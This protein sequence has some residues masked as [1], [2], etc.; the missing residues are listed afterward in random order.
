MVP[1]HEQAVEMAGLAFD[2]RPNP[3]GSE[4]GGAPASSFGSAAYSRLTRPVP[5]SS[6][7]EVDGRDHVSI[8][9]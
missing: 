1:H 3:G 4:V 5:G 9:P 7:I 2:A 8:T 6:S